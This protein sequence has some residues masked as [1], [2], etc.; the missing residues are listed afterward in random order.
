MILKNMFLKIH[1]PNKIQKCIPEKS[2]HNFG[3]SR[4]LPFLQLMAK[5]AENSDHKIGSAFGKEE[6]YL[7]SGL[8]TL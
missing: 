6:I 1:L 4:K 7:P 3:Y 8:K 2:Y 5:I